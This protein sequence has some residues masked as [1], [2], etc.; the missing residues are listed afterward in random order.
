MDWFQTLINC[1]DKNAFSLVHVIF[2]LFLYTFLF[3]Y[4]YVHALFGPF[5]SPTSHPLSLPLTPP[6]FQAESVLPLS[7]ILLKRKHK[8]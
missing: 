5:L 8:Q 1:C 7:L 6:R 3:I 2:I 4:S